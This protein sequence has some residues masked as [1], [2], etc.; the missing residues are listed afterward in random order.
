MVE[1]FCCKC[2]KCGVIDFDFKEVC[3]VV[4]EDGY[5]EVVVMCECLVGE[6]LIEEFMFVVNEIVVEY[7]YWMDVL[8]IY[9]IYED[10]K[11]DKLVWFFEFI[12]NFGL[13]V[14]GIV[15][16]IYLVVL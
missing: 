4:D 14:K 10:L 13:I 12:M 3:V 15:N 6:Y 9:C 7:F 8:F 1:I 16:D 5:L 11:E 2:E